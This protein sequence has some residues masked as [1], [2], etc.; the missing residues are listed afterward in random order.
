MLCEDLP[1]K[2]IT[3][4]SLLGGLTTELQAGGTEGDDI[5][6]L[7]NGYLL[8]NSSFTGSSPE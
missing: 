4:R 8:S 2:P 6:L 5:Q 7:L 1:E 3:L